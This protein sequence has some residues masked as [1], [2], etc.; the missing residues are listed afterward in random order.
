MKREFQYEID[1]DIVTVTVESAAD[2]YI[3]HVG[4]RAYHIDARLGDGGRIDMTTADRRIRA[5]AARDGAKRYVGLDGAS[6]TITKS[7]PRRRRAAR[8]A[9]R[10]GSLTATMP[11][12]VLD[13]LVCAGDAVRKGETLVLMEAMKM[14]LRITA[15]QEGSVVRVNCRA[16]EVV[17][18]G[19]LLIE[20]E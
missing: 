17:Q 5:Y 10:S 18:R 20:L 11:G 12:L 3:V 9:S 13:V 7:D 2:G 4:D 6:W 16:G 14:E 8:D 1:N 19:Q 15:P